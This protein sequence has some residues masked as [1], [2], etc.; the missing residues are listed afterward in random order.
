MEN[1][2]IMDKLTK[3]C[4]CK[5]INRAVIKKAIA[6]GAHSVEAVWAKTGAGSGSCN[7]RR[8]GPKIQL[9]I[10]ESLAQDD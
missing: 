2:E 8:C 10:D 5:A 7:G 6:E 4:L 9:L 1:Q 3:V